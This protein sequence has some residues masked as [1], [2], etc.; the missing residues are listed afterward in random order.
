VSN[1]DFGKRAQTW[2]V[3]LVL[4]VV[5]FLLIIVIIYSLIASRD[6]NNSQLRDD[7]DKIYLY[8]NENDNNRNLPNVVNG[9]TLSEEELTKLYRMDYNELKQTLG[10][11]SDFCII[12]VTDNNALVNVSGKSSIGNGEDVLLAPNIYCGDI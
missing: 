10:I 9:S 11:T 12:V 2:S 5:I 1:S 6:T 4:G 8:L 3:D 7:A